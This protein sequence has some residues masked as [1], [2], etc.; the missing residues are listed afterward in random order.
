MSWFDTTRLASLTKH[1]LKEA[2]KQIDKALD[3]QDD[4]DDDPI[5]K[6][7]R[8]SQNAEPI[9]AATEKKSKTAPST[10]VQQTQPLGSTDSQAAWGSFT[11][12]FFENPNAKE[13]ITTP[14]KSGSG[15]RHS[16]TTTE[17]LLSKR[18]SVTSNSDSVD[19]LS[20][21]TSPST[22]PT[23]PSENVNNS[24]S[25]ELI[26]TPTCSS[27]VVSPDSNASLPES[28][29]IIGS[30][31]DHEEDDDSMSY[32]TVMGESATTK[33]TDMVVVPLAT[34]VKSSESKLIAPLKPQNSAIEDALFESQTVNS[35]ST[36]SFEDVQMVEAASVTSDDKDLVKINS[37]PSSSGHNSN[38]EIETTTS[39]DIE[40]I[41]NPNGDSSSANSAS[42]TSP[43][44][45]AKVVFPPTKKGH[46]R[47]P[48]EV[49]TI[50]EDSQSDTEKLMH[51]ISELSE[52]LESR[53]LRLLELARQNAALQEK[54]NEFQSQMDVMKRKTEH[55]ESEEHTQRL[56]ALEKKFQMSIRERDGLRLQLKTAKEEIQ[57]KIPKNDFTQVVAEKDQMIS[58]LRLEGEKLSKEVLQHSNII[59]KLRAKEKTNEAVL[60]RNKEQIFDLTEEVER[61]KKTLNAKEEVERSQIE[62]VHKISSEK[63]KLEEEN[64]TSRS[65]IEDLNSKLSTLQ[66]SFEVAKVELQ[67][68][69]QV[70][71]DLTKN[72]QELA[73]LRKEKERAELESNEL[74]AQLNELREKL[75]I[76]E[77]GMTMREQKL[78][79]EN[80]ELI[81]RL[82]ESEIRAENLTQEVSLTTIPLMRQLE[83]L[84]S[85]LTMRTNNWDKQ[86]KEF[87]TKLELSRARLQSL[88]NVEC[89]FKEK[90]SLLQSRIETLEEK[91]SASLMQEEQTKIALHQAGLDSKLIE[92]NLKRQLTTLTESFE[93]LKKTHEELK[94]KYTLL[95]EKYETLKTQH[96]KEERPAI[97]VVHR[98]NP[99]NYRNR[100]MSMSEASNSDEAHHTLRPN[101]SSPTLS[102]VDDAL[103]SLDWQV[104]D[105]DCISNSGRQATSVYGMHINLP[106]MSHNASTIEHLTSLVKQRDGEVNQLQWELSRLQV[107]RDVLNSE[108]SNLSMELE[109]IKEKAQLHEDIEKNFAELQRQYDALLQMYGEKV[110]QA[111]EL[112]LDLQDV[113]DMYKAQIDELLRQRNSSV[114]AGGNV[115]GS[116]SSS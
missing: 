39:S 83:S 75:R 31:G 17:P 28:I 56:S 96:K 100:D 105:L 103:G 26:T 61:L 4:L 54:N 102:L 70:H 111:Q 37:G 113:K 21:P 82:E 48:S 58:E 52:I 19:L 27:E 60:K 5:A 46:F 87:L 114:A 16:V 44:K 104:D 50:S 88:E 115:G 79:E 91:L 45:Q 109:N 78:R 92:T 33:T 85:T 24:E 29:V 41:S 107:E 49:S 65:L 95:E 57:S 51:R 99:A 3:I 53:E 63:R 8:L 22:V 71:S 7:K 9:A 110:E 68:R 18:E 40:I 77:A 36:Q 112:E 32:S 80:S 34:E 6:E 74:A 25:V 90:V 11:G 15:Q 23:S 62:A 98:D 14:P 67:N 13:M 101:N 72:T 38:D 97:E 81:R 108:I 42:R 12:S 59:K 76:S 35:D 116:L 69:K 47:E 66:A 94:Q 89:S 43:L 20:P 1:A 10:P 55:L 84:Q 2:Q 64:T 73:T 86:E 30:D 93:D 106:H